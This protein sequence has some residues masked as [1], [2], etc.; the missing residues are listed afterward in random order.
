MSRKRV[1]LFGLLGLLLTGIVGGYLALPRLIMKTHTRFPAAVPDA[2]LNWVATPLPTALPAPA[3]VTDSEQLSVID[4]Q[5]SVLGD[6]LEALQPIAT[7][8]S[9]FHPTRFT[10]HAPDFYTGPHPGTDATAAHGNPAADG[11]SPGND[12]HHPAKV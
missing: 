6:Q 9:H 5:L 1:V 7:A 4:N 8:F 10:F 3:S 12:R 2:L 11:R